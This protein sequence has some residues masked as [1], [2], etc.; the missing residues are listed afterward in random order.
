MRFETTILSAGGSGEITASINFS[1]GNWLT[2]SDNV[3][4]SL[5]IICFILYSRA[6]T[7]AMLWRDDLH[8]FLVKLEEVEEKERQQELNVNKKTA[9]ANVSYF[10]F[11]FIFCFL[12]A[13]MQKH[14]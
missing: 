9:K 6:K 13:M 2:W 3:V 8:D 5:I 11:I 14:C 4:I 10:R 1:N 7:P 12:S